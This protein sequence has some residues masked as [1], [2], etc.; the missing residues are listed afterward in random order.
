MSINACDARNA[1]IHLQSIS[2]Q[3]LEIDSCAKRFICAG[4]VCVTCSRLER[5]KEGL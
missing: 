4:M 5:S 2:K 1:W 3:K